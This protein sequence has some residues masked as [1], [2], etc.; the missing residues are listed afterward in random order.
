MINGLYVVYSEDLFMFI[1][2]IKTSDEKNLYK[3]KEYSKS[4]VEHSHRIISSI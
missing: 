4:I 2:I 3:N 1:T